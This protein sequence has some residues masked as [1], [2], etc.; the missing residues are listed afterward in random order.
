MTNTA[1]QMLRK[2]QGLAGPFPFLTFSR[3]AKGSLAAALEL[4][5]AGLARVSAHAN[6]EIKVGLI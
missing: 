4:Q 1:S 6:G 2:L 5:A 3:K